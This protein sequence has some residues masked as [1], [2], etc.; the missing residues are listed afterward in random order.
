MSLEGS[1]ATG[2]EYKDALTNMK[3]LGYITQGYC[4]VDEN[5]ENLADDGLAP[6]DT[7]MP[8]INLGSTHRI[9]LLMRIV[10]LR[11]LR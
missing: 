11:A 3:E 4:V 6:A 1:R 7:D 9:T 5:G 2:L 8:V 10:L